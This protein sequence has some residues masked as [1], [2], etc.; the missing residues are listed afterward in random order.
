[1]EGNRLQAKRLI[2]FWA[3][4][5]ILAIQIAMYAYV[6]YHY[7]KDLM[8]FQYYRRGNW[9]VIGMY[10]IFIFAFN[11]AFGALKV[12]YLK[13]WDVMYS[14]IFAIACT[15]IVTYVQLVLINGDWAIFKGLEAY[16]DH[17][18]PILQLCVLDFIVVFVWA[19]FMRWIYAI[20]YPPHE[21]LLIYGDRSP[22]EIAQKLVKRGDK[23]QIKEMIC[24]TEGED[25]II[26]KM[27]GFESVLVGDI[28]S[29]ERNLFVK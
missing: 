20:I 2:M 10:A 27:K 18:V 16:F 11:K 28:P 4:I 23:Y 9:A 7:Y 14:Q 5:L 29:H 24:L 15:N 6:W 8:P 3:K 22:K 26:E 1:M 13:T 21:M 17:F 19:L 12:G 25:K